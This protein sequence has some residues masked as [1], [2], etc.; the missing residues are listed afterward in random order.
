MIL[1][2]LDGEKC[3]KS[4]FLIYYSIYYLWLGQIH[5]WFRR[6]WNSGSRNRIRSLPADSP[7]SKKLAAFKHDLRNVEQERKLCLVRSWRCAHYYYYNSG[8]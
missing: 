5:S 6:N 3:F 7:I 1:S 2:L 8:L 4:N